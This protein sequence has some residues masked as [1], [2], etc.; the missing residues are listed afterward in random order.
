[1]RTDDIT[2]LIF[3]PLS[4]KRTG[5]VEFDIQFPEPLQAI[6]AV[7]SNGKALRVEAVSQDKQTNRARMR[8]VATD[9]PANGYQTIRLHQQMANVWNGPL[10]YLIATDT[11]LENEFL[12]LAID[13]ATGC[14]T[15]LIDKRANTEALA[16]AVPGVGSPPTLPDGKPCGN[17]LQAF[18]DK[19]QKWDAWNVDSDFIEHH[20]DLLQADEVKLIE[21]TGI[22]AVIRVKHTWQNSS[23]IQDITLSARGREHADGMAREAHP[24]EGRFPAERTQRQGHLRDSLRYSRASDHAQHSSRTGAVRGPGAALG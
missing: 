24:A 5:P 21:H 17:L 16:P 1:V 10:I 7:D 19:P 8:L 13:P 14:I 22:R 9:I 20:S 11:S 18:V 4:W 2:V 6:S 15:S 3:N 12:K 23:F